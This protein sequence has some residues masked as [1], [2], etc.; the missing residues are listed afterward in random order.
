MRT[1]LLI[2]VL[3]G[4]VVAAAWRIAGLPGEVT[5]DIGEIGYTASVPVT[6]LLLAV[7]FLLLYVALRLLAWVVSLPRRLS[8][9]RARRRRRNGEI[10]VTRTLV[11]LAAGEGADARREVLRARR[12]LGDTP[13][14]LLLTAEASRAAGREDEAE[15]AFET[16]ALRDDA[17]FLGLRGLLRAAIAREDWEQASELARRAEA[18]HPGASW[19]RGERLNLALRAKD[20]KLALS[21][22]PEDARS[23]GPTRAALA[24]AAAQA[25][26]DA[27]TGRKLAKRAFEADQGSPAAALAYARR[28]RENGRENRVAGVIRSAWSA[29]PQ[30][31]LIAF[32]LEPVTDKLERLRVA[33]RL[34]AGNGD[35]PETHLVMGR[36]ALEAG[37]LMEARRHAEAAR[38]AVNQ[39]RIWML[40]ADIEE[41]EGGDTEAG[42]LAQREA[43]RH[44][45][46]AGSDPAWR[47]G[48]CGTAHAAWLPVC[49]TC[50][51]AGRIAWGQPLAPSLLLPAR[52]G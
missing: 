26:P 14:T 42:R 18:A 38:H 3:C 21:L 24:T 44:A 4:V 6:I 8:E 30:P 39:S 50:G 35:H 9:G 15:A 10:A 12:L 16:L 17:A 7:L 34:T 52:V 37:E 41:A 46:T 28:L 33:E 49:P 45:A 5:A 51:T 13:Q 32:A 47:C 31:E 36:L 19:L 27:S 2:L 11:A 23:T 48:A 1:V 29:N 43:L 25:E 22:L 20:W 40:L